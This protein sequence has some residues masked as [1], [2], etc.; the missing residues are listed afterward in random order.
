M[1]DYCSLRNVTNHGGIM[2]LLSV[3]RMVL[4]SLSL[5]SKNLFELHIDTSLEFRVLKKILALLE[6]KKLIF[7]KNEYFSFNKEEFKKLNHKES[8][9]D[10]VSELTEALVHSSL[11][12]NKN[13]SSIN[14][15]KVS[16]RKEDEGIFQALISNLDNFIKEQQERC[17]KE[18]TNGRLCEQRMFLWGH[19]N[20]GSVVSETL[21][22]S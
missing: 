4:E 21:R 1:L 22:I 16:I 5:S 3:E 8:V 17:K 14:L 15:Q 6:E 11:T 12:R 18:K 13:E 10:E 7:K 2:S 20:Y 9:K 19:A